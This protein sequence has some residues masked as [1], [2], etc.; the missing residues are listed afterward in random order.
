MPLDALTL[1]YLALLFFVL[2]LVIRAA[3][4]GSDLARDVR[5]IRILLETRSV[6]EH[7][8]GKDETEEVASE[9]EE[10]SICPACG[11]ELSAGDNECPACGL[12]L[13]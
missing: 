13:K 2:F 6:A 12:T 1:I 3:I 11:E 9:A 4:N 10:E 5:K 8:T 7:R